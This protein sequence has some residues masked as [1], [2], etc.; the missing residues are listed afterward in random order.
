MEAKKDGEFTAV[1]VILTKT[2]DTEHSRTKKEDTAIV[3]SRGIVI[4]AILNGNGK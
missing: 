1:L 3:L 2:S 4:E